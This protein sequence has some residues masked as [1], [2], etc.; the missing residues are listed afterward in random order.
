M[1]M[2]WNEAYNLPIYQRDWLM[3]RYIEE[4]ERE[5]EQHEKYLEELKHKK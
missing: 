3:N 4:K 5:N 2:S 1:K